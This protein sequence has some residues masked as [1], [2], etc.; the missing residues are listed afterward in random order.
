MYK[1]LKAPLS[2]QVEMT[3][4]CS[5]SCV[6]CYNYWR[7][8]AATVH[9]TL[10]PDQAETIADKLAEAEVFEVVV[11]GGEPLLA[12]EAT[13]A[14]IRRA[15]S[16]GLVV[17]LNSTLK[18]LTADDARWFREQGVTSVLTS[19][20]GPEDIHDDVVHCPGAFAGTIRG[21]RLAR[22]AGLTVHVNMVISQA[23]KGN[24]LDTAR[25][26]ES[27]D[28][29]LFLATKA[30]QPENCPEFAPLRLT[31]ADIEDYVH[32]LRAASLTMPVEML[33]TYPLCGITDTTDLA[34]H[35]RRCLAGVAQLTISSDGTARPCNHTDMAYGSIWDHSICDLW[36]R[37][38]EWRFGGFLPETC[39]QCAALMLCGG[40]CRMEAK[41]HMGDIRAL[42]PYARPD[43]LPRIIP[44]LRNREQTPAHA[45][46]AF[47]INPSRSRQETFG[48]VL[49]A[50][51]GAPLML[52]P[53]GAQ[54]WQ[55]FS[56]GRIY[57]IDEPGINWRGVDKI[58][59]LAALERKKLISAR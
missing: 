54:V 24:V 50:H 7:H 59:F 56:A 47:S 35:G 6:H 43:N 20:H 32:E 17:T 8:D 39:R 13:R 11:T 10:T 1:Q 3:T 22:A 9:A 18:Q 41:T 53:E 21:I 40:G 37:M 58:A 27:L 16:L 25:L 44:F 23:N 46:C 15:R 12:P 5:N 45:P 49:C 57:F 42:D 36:Q 28:V 51:G 14:L 30:A 19:I 26:C 31:S 33:S 4:G 2:V 48:T 29:N 52:S 55:Q 34:L 38:D